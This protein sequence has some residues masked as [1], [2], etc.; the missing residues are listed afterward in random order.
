MNNTAGTAVIKLRYDSK[1]LEQS[2]GEIENSTKSM[3]GKL[4]GAAKIT[5]KL[6]VAGIA[7]TA[8]AVE[9]LSIASV[10]AYADYEQ[11]VGGVETLFKENA[12]AVIENSQR[13]FETAQINATE[14]MDQAVKMSASLIQS[15]G[16]DTAKAADY[17]DRAIRDMA[18]N[19]MKMGTSLEMIQNAY[20]GF[21]KQNYMMLDNLRL[22]YGGTKTEMERLIADASQM[23]DEMAELGVTVDAT[24]LDFANIVNAIEV[25]QKHLDIAGTAAEEA[26]TTISGSF[27]SMKAAAAN[28]IT[29]FA[30]P[31]ADL[32]KLTENL[33]NRVTI[34]A[35][36]LIPAVLRSLDGI[37]TALEKAIPELFEKTNNLLEKFLP[38][39]IDTAVSLFGRIV[40]QLPN[41]VQTLLNLMQQVLAKIL[42]QIPII[43]RQIVNALLGIV[44]V[45]LEPQ[46]IT[47]IITAGI[48]LLMALV[49][50]IP[51]IITALT[52]ALPDI[53][54][55][56]V[57]WLTSPEAFAQILDATLTL[58]GALVAA[59]PQI[60]GAL[61]KAFAQLFVNLYA[62]MSEK[63]QNFATDFGNKI[64]DIMS[65]AI[66]AVIGYLEDLLNG[67]IDAI[68][69][70]IDAINT[71]PGVDIGRLSRIQLN[72]VTLATGG[73]TKGPT[74]AL[75]G[76][77]G[78]EA[79]IPL[80]Q[81][82]GN[83]AGLLAGK[84]AEEF[85]SEPGEKIVNV[86]INNKIDSRLDIQ[87]VCQELTQAVRR[88][89]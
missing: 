50:A 24:S 40:E 15:L 71:I 18:D 33:F 47:M 23:T 75:I 60:L 48:S 82:T 83:W 28:L 1:S 76:E 81:N 62:M 11:M 61:L 41:L 58:L 22:G 59:V 44:K 30:T 80:E 20:Q 12:D 34:F 52:E 10:R 64:K 46:N 7:A 70:V 68:N 56:I 65:R 37:G 45:L 39:L 79:V 21:A 84:L 66:N 78:R 57:D 8:A 87:T 31:E 63:F 69:L 74:N 85:E 19:S 55:A 53:I 13:A 5:G 36:N 89:A 35:E 25:V 26:N 86:Y 9:G 42:P 2:Q 73:V 54:T 77:A 6:A 49:Q 17:A 67:P 32:E 38:K 51:E 16:G 88:A 27:A 29:G 72:R 4:G 14:Y 43:I 3:L